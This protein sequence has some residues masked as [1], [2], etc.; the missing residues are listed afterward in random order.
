MQRNINRFLWLLLPVLVAT[1]CDAPEARFRMNMAYLHKNEK[2]AEAFTAEQKADVAN[3]L[4]ALFGTPDQPHLPQ[5]AGLEDVISIDRLKMAAGPVGVDEQGIATGLY[6]QHCS[7]CHGVSGDGNGPTAAYL[8]PYP[9]DYRMG[10]FKFKSTGKGTP[11]THEDLLRIL[12]EGVPGTAMPSFRLLPDIEREAIVDYVKYLAIRG[13]VERRLMEDIAIELGPGER[14]DQSG[15]YLVGE[16]VASAVAKWSAAEEEVTEVPARPDDWN[17]S[18]A[19]ARGRELFHGAVANCV[20]CHGETQLGD[21]QRT[22]YDEWSKDYEDFSKP[23][24]DQEKQKLVDELV[25]LGG[26]PPRN[27]FPRNLREGIYRG[28]RRPEELYRR[29]TNGIDGT[30]MPAATMKPDDAPE[31]QQGLTAADV[32]CIVDYIRSLPY[33][34][35]GER[36]TYGQEFKRERM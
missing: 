25:E 31:Q 24:T 27:I 6:R 22:D 35:G 19:I 28:G 3:I 8:N 17:E 13:Q 15:E 21:G 9:R 32:W 18:A 4:A 33:E 30:P 29:I 36:A 23:M 1:G 20:K 10:I 34:P 7:H 14:L 16:I 2:K 26:L 11:P 12:Y 5:G